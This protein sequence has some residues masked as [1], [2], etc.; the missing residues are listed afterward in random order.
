MKPGDVIPSN[1]V[2]IPAD[3]AKEIATHFRKVNAGPNSRN[4]KWADLLD[5]QPP[6]LRE[7]VAEVVRAHFGFTSDGLSNYYPCADAVLA[8]VADWLAA[9][10]LVGDAVGVSDAAGLTDAQRD[11]DVRL[12]RGQS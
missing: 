12:L 2:I 6:S 1:S 8:V 5:P 7:Q 3:V 11:H 4:E 10:P 9:Q